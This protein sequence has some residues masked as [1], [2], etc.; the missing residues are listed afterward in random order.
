MGSA[1][2][3]ADYDWKKAV[4]WDTAEEYDGWLGSWSG[5]T[6]G[7]DAID[8]IKFYAAADGTI[9]IQG[10]GAENWVLLDKKGN[11]IDDESIFAD[12]RFM[13]GGNYIIKVN[14]DDTEKSLAY[15]IKLA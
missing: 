14:V 15:T 4:K 11:I 5:Y 1:Y 9:D 13:V 6:D 7:C 3:Q 12:G 2:E 8:H 10:I